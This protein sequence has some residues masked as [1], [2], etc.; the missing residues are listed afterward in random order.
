MPGPL[1][2]AGGGYRVLVWG[3][4]VAEIP[5]LVNGLRTDSLV[6]GWE[7]K[8]ANRNG[9]YHAPLRPKP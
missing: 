9:S 1:W 2:L 4:E 5:L 7:L 8:N 6:A 3:V